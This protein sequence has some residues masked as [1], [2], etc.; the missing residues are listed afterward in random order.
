MEYKIRDGDGEV[1]TFKDVN[2]VLYALVSIMGG[3]EYEDCEYGIW[4]EGG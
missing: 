4:I 3:H 1:Y 2:E